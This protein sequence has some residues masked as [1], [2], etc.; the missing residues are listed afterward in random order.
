VIKSRP[1]SYNGSTFGPEDSFWFMAMDGRAWHSSVYLRSVFIGQSEPAPTS[2]P[3]RMDGEWS[4]NGFLL[5][6]RSL[7][8]CGG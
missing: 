4:G 7:A 5:G 8:N 3:G 1:V 6:F 2:A